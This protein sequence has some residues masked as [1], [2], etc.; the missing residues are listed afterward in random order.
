[1]SRQKTLR[2]GPQTFAPHASPA[3]PVLE[4]SPL[5]Q[6]RRRIS[7]E[8]H[9]QPLQTLAW[10]QLRLAELNRH[11]GSAHIRPMIEDIR[12]LIR[13]VSQQLRHVIDGLVRPPAGGLRLDDALRTS[14]REMHQRFTGSPSILLNLQGPRLPLAPPLMAAVLRAVQELLANLRKHSEASQAFLSSSCLQRCVEV[15]LADC[16]RGFDPTLIDP[17]RGLASIRQRL[18]AVGARLMIDSRPGFGTCARVVI[19]M[20]P[21]HHRRFRV[22]AP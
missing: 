10:A 5:E 19:P 18:E 8:L 12:R 17:S 22:P 9:D 11:E 2:A 16:G 1:M 14:V 21:A 7:H 6:E 3:T 15:V 20:A 4:L 13:D